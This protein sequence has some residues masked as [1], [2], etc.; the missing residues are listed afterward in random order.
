MFNRLQNVLYF[1]LLKLSSRWNFLILTD[2]NRFIHCSLI[3][4]QQSV[5]ANSFFRV[6]RT[7]WRFS[8]S[9]M[10]AHAKLSFDHQVSTAFMLIFDNFRTKTMTFIFTGITPPNT[11]WFESLFHLFRRMNWE[12]ISSSIGTYIIG[13]NVLLIQDP[14]NPRFDVLLYNIKEN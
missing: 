3:W 5:G 1:V 7:A 10:R 13:R 9:Q 4:N 2:D 12:E 6:F 8:Y 11:G 14:Q